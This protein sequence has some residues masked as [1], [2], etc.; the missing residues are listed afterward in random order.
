MTTETTETTDD[1]MKTQKISI[2]NIFRSLMPFFIGDGSG[3]QFFSVVVLVRSIPF[4][5]VLT[6]APTKKIQNPKSISALSG[7]QFFSVVVLVRSIPFP[8]VL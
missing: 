1:K 2:P 8:R 7:Q 5:R 4:P 6:N 3:H